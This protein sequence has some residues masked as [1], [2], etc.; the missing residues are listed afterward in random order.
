MNQTL[1]VILTLGGLVS[2]LY[3]GIQYFRDSESFGVL[4]IEVFVSRRSLTPV[5]ASL[6]VLGVGLILLRNSGD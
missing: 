6:V 2:F 3:T 4:G 1:G 5:V